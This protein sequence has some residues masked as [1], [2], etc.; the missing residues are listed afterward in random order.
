MD[1]ARHRLAGALLRAHLVRL[2]CPRGEGV[3]THNVFFAAVEAIR[4]GKAGPALVYHER[5]YKRV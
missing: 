2:P 1:R 3:G 4:H 5:V